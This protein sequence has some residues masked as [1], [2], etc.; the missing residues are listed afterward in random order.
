MMYRLFNEKVNRC[1]PLLP[2]SFSPLRMGWPP[3]NRLRPHIVP[4]YGVCGT[5]QRLV[6]TM[7]LHNISSE[8]DKQNE[9]SY[10]WIL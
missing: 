1:H 9:T 8:R 6:G 2:R 3:M 5:T 4:F 7:M 10:I